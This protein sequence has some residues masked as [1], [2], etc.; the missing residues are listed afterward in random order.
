M[1]AQIHVCEDYEKMGKPGSKPKNSIKLDGAKIESSSSTPPTSHTNSPAYGSTT[2]AVNGG[3]KLSSSPASLPSSQNGTPGDYY[4]F[5]VA[6]SNGEVHEFR[7]DTENE[8][9]RWVK[10]LQL[11]VMYPYS[12]I[13][14]EPE[15]NPISNR[16]RQTLEAKQYGAGMLCQGRGGGGEMGWG[17][18]GGQG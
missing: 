8:R 15:T 5:I 14:E 7:T 12:I 17:G 3:L 11:L 10:L 18:G 4:A 6:T 16:F 1:S 13:P 2:L 9:L